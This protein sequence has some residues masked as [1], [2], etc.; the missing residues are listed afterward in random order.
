MTAAAE[1]TPLTPRQMDVYAWIYRRT[2]ECGYQPSYREIA[3]RFG[4]R[5]HTNGV[6][7]FLIALQ[8]KGYLRVT[9]ARGRALEFLVRPDGR[10]FRGFAD[11]ED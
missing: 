8:R 7:S 3:A 1:P 11:R 4:W 6:R 10:P 5:S 9:P 2:R